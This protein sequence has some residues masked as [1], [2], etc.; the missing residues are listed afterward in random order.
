MGEAKK[1][2][3][4]PAVAREITPAECGENRHSRY[5]CPESC[6]HNPFAVAA[7]SELLEIEDRLDLTAMK[8]LA[9]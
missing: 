1:R 8:R 5:A 3:L 7:Y 9:L 2:R 6:T 4:C